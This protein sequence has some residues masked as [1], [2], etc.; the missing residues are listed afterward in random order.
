MYNCLYT[1]IKKYNLE[2]FDILFKKDSLSK[3]FLMDFI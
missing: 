3:S 2:I 1:A